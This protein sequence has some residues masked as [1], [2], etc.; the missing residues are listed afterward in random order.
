MDYKSLFRRL[1]INLIIGQ[2]DP[3]IDMFKSVWDTISVVNVCTDSS[4]NMQMVYYT[5]DKNWKLYIDHDG[6]LVWIN[7]SF[8][9]VY[10][11][12][13]YTLKHREIQNIIA[14]LITEVGNIDVST[15]VNIG[16]V[17]AF[18]GD[19]FYAVATEVICSYPLF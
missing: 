2:S 11:E 18:H 6:D 15:G 7:Y 3:I 12:I 8:I 13:N 19:G 16:S 10:L 14:L 17:S 1:T 4:G 9:W 5:P